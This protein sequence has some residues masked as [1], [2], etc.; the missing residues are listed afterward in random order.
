MGGQGEISVQF[1]T[2][3]TLPKFGENLAKTWTKLGKKLRKNFRKKLNQ[4]MAKQFIKNM[5]KSLA[6][7]Y[8]F[9]RQNNENFFKTLKKN[10]GRN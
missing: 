8:N 9:F 1:P 4:N 2:K 3:I 5:D 10:L 6:K 7:S